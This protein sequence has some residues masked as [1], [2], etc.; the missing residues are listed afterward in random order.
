VGSGEDCM[1]RSFMI[2]TPGIVVLREE[3][4]FGVENSA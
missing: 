4:K 1:M 2:C 3:Y